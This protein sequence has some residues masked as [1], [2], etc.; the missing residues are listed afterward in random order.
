M[1][2]HLYTYISAICLLLVCSC[3]HR[4]S[5]PPQFLVADSLA[6]VQ[7]DS[8]IALLE[9]L[10]ADSLQWDKATQMYHTLLTVKAHDKAYIPQTSDRLMLQVLHYYEHG[11]DKCLLPEAYYYM[12]STYRD[13]GDAPRA[14]EY[15]QKALEVLP[16]GASPLRR[17]VNNQMGFLF[18]RQK[19]YDEALSCYQN[20]F[21]NDSILGNKAEMASDL[22]NIGYIYRCKDDYTSSLERYLF[23]KNMISD[24]KDIKVMDEI[25]TQIASIYLTFGKYEEAKSAIQSPL[26]H[27]N[28]ST[29]NVYNVAAD[30]YYKLGIIDTATIL[31]KTLLEV[32]NVYGKQSAYE[33]LG[34]ISAQE[35]NS[36]NA[37][38]YFSQFRLM[39]DSIRRIT[40]TESIAEMRSIYNYQK[41]IEER[42][43]IMKR[44]N[45]NRQIILI[46]LISFAIIII[47]T[48]N[49]INRIRHAKRGLQ[50]KMNEL[51]QN[52][53][54]MRHI[55]ERSIEDKN[56]HI[57]ELNAQLQNI[58]D[59]NTKQSN[60]IEEMQIQL[61]QQVAEEEDK[62]KQRSEMDLRLKKTEIYGQIIYLINKRE[63]RLSL[64][65]FDKL[66][67]TF[68]TIAPEYMKKVMSLCIL[69][70]IEMQII[71]LSRMGISPNDIAFL[72]NYSK[73]NISNIR[74]RLY[75]KLSGED[76]GASYLDEYIYM[77]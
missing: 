57:K 8:A 54:T 15:Y 64:K 24:N 35:K 67:E 13:L 34:V 37:A 65:N 29:S 75:K 36:E 2:A 32:G 30:I 41:A 52:L 19:L 11:G 59:A 21:T 14:L 18:Y 73:S 47:A 68:N 63:E 50:N 55:A 4:Q 72:T 40:A 48:H 22:V 38:N 74:N 58:V 33:K 49:Y 62:Q 6:S 71:L 23:A 70:D 25:D 9:S 12:G 61:L 26:S 7:S 66:K 3:Q 44:N 20:S 16:E 5:Y 69:N 60:L 77:I 1:K 46:L 53:E 31:Y 42:E 27:V 56:E 10:K 43:A 45:A 17:Y 39:T 76:R 51:E 28:R